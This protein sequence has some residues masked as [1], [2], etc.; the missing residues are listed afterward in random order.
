VFETL[1]G[2]CKKYGDRCLTE[3]VGYGIFI[4]YGMLY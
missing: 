3:H 2:I 1:I 4:L